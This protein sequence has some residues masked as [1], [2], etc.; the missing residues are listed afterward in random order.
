MKV[1]ISGEQAEA[2]GRTIGLALKSLV[3][4][5]ISP[6]AAA[7]GLRK[8]SGKTPN[9]PRHVQVVATV[10]EGGDYGIA[11]ERLERLF[12]YIKNRIIDECRI[13]PILL[14]LLTAR[15]E[16]VV[17][18][19]PRIVTLDASN[20]KGRVAR[21]MAAGWFSTQR[22]TSAVRRELARTGADPGGG[23]SLSDVLN[24]YVKDGFLV[25]EGEGQFVFAP[26]VKVTER[27]I[28]A[29]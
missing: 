8:G 16:L 12:V 24:N 5:G 22:A 6:E 17:E 7:L 25:R 18:V 29:T 14:Q 15:P 9:D 3:D 23:G 2:I 26:G 13:D 11:P 1:K 4:D 21:L 20:L 27:E 19:E 28:K 10:D